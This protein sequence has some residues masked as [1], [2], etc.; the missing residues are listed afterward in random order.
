MTAPVLT[1]YAATTDYLMASLD[2]PNSLDTE[3][4]KVNDA[5]DTN[6]Y[7]VLGGEKL[8]FNATHVGKTIRMRYRSLSNFVLPSLWTSYTVTEPSDSSM[9]LYQSVGQGEYDKYIRWTAAENYSEYRYSI[10]GDVGKEETVT[11]ASTSN[12]YNLLA[13]CA[14]ATCHFEVEA[15]GHIDGDDK[16]VYLQ[17][18]IVDDDFYT[19]YL[20]A[21]RVD[22]THRLSY[23]IYAAPEGFGPHPLSVSISIRTA[24]NSATRNTSALEGED[25][26]ITDTIVSLLEGKTGTQSTVV[27]MRLTDSVASNYN[28]NKAFLMNNSFVVNVTRYAPSGGTIT[29]GMNG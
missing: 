21:H 27:S 26:D 28:R 16:V 5:A 1:M 9:T 13:S 29:Y 14:R 19:V 18:K 12:L 10:T 8:Q 3:N 22:D 17:K 4:Y 6:E 25:V 2:K 24:N 11:E 7:D 20:T 15:V 23:D